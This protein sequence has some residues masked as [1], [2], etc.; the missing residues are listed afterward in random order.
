M[1]KLDKLQILFQKRNARSRGPTSSEQYNDMVDELGHDLTGISDQWNNR[2]VPLL[3]TLPDGTIGTSPLDAFTNG[4]DG[5]TIYVDSAATAAVEVKY[6]NSVASRPNSLKEQFVDV[7]NQIDSVNT[8]LQAQIAGLSFSASQ[9]SF[10][11]GTVAANNVQAA[12]DK[13]ANDLANITTGGSVGAGNANEVAVFNAAGDVVGDAGLTYDPAT[14]TLTGVTINATNSSITTLT[15]TTASATTLTVNGDA[16]VSNYINLT[17]Q[18][19]TPVAPASGVRLFWNSNETVGIIDSIGNTHQLP[20]ASTTLTNNRLAYVDS[21]GILTTSSIIYDTTLSKVS[22]PLGWTLDVGAGDIK[23]GPLALVEQTA[24]PVANTTAITLYALNTS[25]SVIYSVDKL[26]TTRRVLTT[27]DGAPTSSPAWDGIFLDSEGSARSSQT[28]FYYDPNLRAVMSQAPGGLIVETGGSPNKSVLI[29]TDT[30]RT[31]PA[32]IGASSVIIGDASD[33]AGQSVQIG[34]GQS[35]TP[36]AYADTVR[37]GYMAEA[38]LTNGHYSFG[39]S[40]NVTNTAFISCGRGYTLV[41][42][43]GEILAAGDIVTIKSLGSSL[44]SALAAYKATA[45]AAGAFG[46]ALTAASGP[47]VHVVV[48]IKGITYVNINS[49]TASIGNLITTSTTAGLGNISTTF[50]VNSFV[51][52]V[53]VNYALATTSVLAMIG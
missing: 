13:V 8:S 9:I 1:A 51:G 49:S 21:T 7:Y 35:A 48:M 11:P 10:T 50:N 18:Q 3:T 15:S 24:A 39:P 47:G 53:L 16:A 28:D 14:T 40:S 31:T 30:T 22:L 32:T 33:N 38:P 42:P 36:N 34:V 45:T 44:I 25:N 19:L 17:T 20:L 52:K 5:K 12:I 23:S 37:I 41:M 43:A 2:L 6:F 46:V 26:G 27:I 29:S 4:L